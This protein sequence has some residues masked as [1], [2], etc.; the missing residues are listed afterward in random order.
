MIIKTIGITVSYHDENH[1]V[2][3]SG[4]RHTNTGK[5]DIVT[6]LKDNMHS[7]QMFVF[8]SINYDYFDDNNTALVNSKLPSYNLDRVSM[9]ADKHKSFSV[10]REITPLELMLGCVK[11][12]NNIVRFDN[13]KNKQYKYIHKDFLVSVA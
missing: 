11:L 7:N 4:L 10:G 8:F 2:I 3:D 9:L 12:N 1:P 13:V 6:N 5:Q